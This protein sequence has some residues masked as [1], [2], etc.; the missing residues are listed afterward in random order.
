MLFLLL[1]HASLHQLVL[2]PVFQ[3]VGMVRGDRTAC[4]EGNGAT[5]E[6]VHARG[7][8]AQVEERYQRMEVG[9]MAIQ[10][11]VAA[12]FRAGGFSSVPRT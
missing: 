9:Q 1:Q 6:D 3:S 11:W 7:D 10:A 5:V 2:E 8:V 4:K 12:L